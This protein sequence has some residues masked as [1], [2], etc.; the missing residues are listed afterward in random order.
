MPMY[1]A[2][3]CLS[4]S[5]DAFFT[6]LSRI[7]D[8]LPPTGPRPKVILMG[9]SSGGQLAAL[10]SQHVTAPD[11]PFRDLITGVL[12]RCPV[13]SDVFSG[14]EYVPEYLRQYHTSA[15]EPF[16]TPLVGFMHRAVPRDGLARMPLEASAEILARLPRTWIQL[17]T[18]DVLYSDGVCYGIALERA[19]VEVRADFI[20]GWPHTFWLPAPHLDRAVQADEAMV[21]GL[22]WLLS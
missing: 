17:C 15:S 6:I 10:V 22:K 16:L 3:I 2:S 1:S 20:E 21:D 18:N 8:S 12:L 4:D 19:G 5:I 7:H 11:S 14:K 13:T 9:S